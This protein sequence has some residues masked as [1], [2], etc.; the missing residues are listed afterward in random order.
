MSKNLTNGD[1]K[2][3]IDSISQS[4]LSKDVE[5]YQSL[6]YNDLRELLVR[7][8]E[9]SPLMVLAMEWISN[10]S[11]TPDFVETY[12]DAF[13]YF[14]KFSIR[15]HVGIFSP[16][17]E[18]GFKYDFKQQ[19]FSEFLQLIRSKIECCAVN[20]QLYY[21]SLIHSPAK[22]VEK[23]VAILDT[24]DSTRSQRKNA[25]ILF[26]NSVWRDREI[27]SIMQDVHIKK[28]QSKKMEAVAS[29]FQGNLDFDSASAMLRDTRDEDNEVK[30]C[31]SFFSVISSIGFLFAF[32]SQRSID[33]IFKEIN[34]LR[35]L[36]LSRGFEF[37]F[38]AYKCLNEDSALI[39][40]GWVANNRGSTDV[41][42]AEYFL[43]EARKFRL[44]SHELLRQGVLLGIPANVKG[45]TRIDIYDYATEI[46][47]L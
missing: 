19:Y 27:A 5:T 11:N 43:N 13:C 18:F 22:C 46:T 17:A 44:Q 31:Q 10:I 33:L 14:Y 1:L 7:S 3:L 37:E 34:R 32:P 2:R 4:Y 41:L 23:C 26:C 20:Q 47:I 29:M 25:G 38:D 45:R 24:P 12:L 8:D 30:W 9:V 35:A 21:Y 6:I 15:N 28:I 36:P 16:P 39:F 40:S 42:L